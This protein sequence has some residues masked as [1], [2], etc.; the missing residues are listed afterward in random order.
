MYPITGHA[1]RLRPA[2]V[3]GPLTTCVGI[4][5]DRPPFFGSTL[6]PP[7]FQRRSES[8]VTGHTLSLLKK[9]TGLE[10][11]KNAQRAVEEGGRQVTATIECNRSASLG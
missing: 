6:L 8:T 1:G 9:H 10:R 11:G 4:T 7:E 5:R 2:G 3:Q